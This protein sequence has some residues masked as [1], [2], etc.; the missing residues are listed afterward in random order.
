MMNCFLLEERI[1][2]RDE[3]YHHGILGQ[4]WGV[5]RYQNYDGTLTN[6]GQ[7]RYGVS[8]NRTAKQ[9]QNRLN[10]LDQAMAYS[11]RDYKEVKNK[12]DAL[13]KKLRKRGNLVTEDGSG[14]ETYRFSNSGRDRK[15]MDKL[16]LNSEK[17]ARAT[18]SIKLGEKETKKLLKEAKKNHYVV[19]SKD[20]SRSAMRGKDYVGVALFG[21]IPYT[22]A[23]S[24]NIMVKD[25]K[26]YKV[27]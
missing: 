16:I 20:V 26:I 11:K 4:K 2:H 6:A 15:A 9:Y 22:L 23:N 1:M 13:L 17:M 10:D 3:L 7:K 24:N 25:S 12:Q 5:R 14:K 27:R 19:T 21:S 8:N 18:N